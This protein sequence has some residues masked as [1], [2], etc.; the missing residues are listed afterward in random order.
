MDNVPDGRGV[1][2]MEIGR[3]R[4]T[5]SEAQLRTNTVEFMLI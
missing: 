5:V 3:W 4:H 1:Y 2:L